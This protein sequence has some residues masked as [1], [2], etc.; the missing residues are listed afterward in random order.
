MDKENRKGSYPFHLIA[1]K[2]YLDAKHQFNELLKTNPNDGDA[3]FALGLI[4]YEQKKYQQAENYLKQSLNSASEKHLSDIT[5]LLGAINQTMHQPQ[6]ALKYY[7]KSIQHATANYFVFNNMAILYKELNQF[8]KAHAHIN[9]ALSLKPNDSDCLNTLSLIYKKENKLSEAINTCQQ[10]LSLD[11]QYSRAWNNLGNLY[12]QQ[13]E[14]N[15]AI[16]CYKKALSIEPKYLDCIN[17]LAETYGNHGHYRKAI[18]YY[19]QALVLNPEDPKQY[20]YLGIYHKKL[21]E[22]DKS[23][24]YYHKALALDP[25]LSSALN[26]LGLVYQHLGDYQQSLSYL[27]KALRLNKDS[28]EYLNNIAI[29]YQFMGEEEKAYEYFNK[30][31]AC[32]NPLHETRFNRSLLLLKKGRLENAWVEFESRVQLPFSK[33]LRE[34]IH[35]LT[36]LSRLT[37]NDSIENN[38][39]LILFEQGLGDFIQYIRFAKN[40]KALGAIVHVEVPLE[41]IS[42]IKTNDY[43]DTVYEYGSSTLEDGYYIPILSLPY[44]LKLDLYSLSTDIPYFSI[45]EK[46]RAAF[47]SL[48]NKSKLNVGLVWGGN[49]K[50][51]ND[52]NRSIP[53]HNF[54]QLITDENINTCCLQVGEYHDQLKESALRQYMTDLSIHLQTFADTAAMISCLDLIISVDTSIVHLAGAL[55]VPCWVLLPTNADWRWFLNSTESIWYSSVRLFRKSLHAS[56]TT[57]IDEV[58]H[59]LKTNHLDCN[60]SLM[61]T[62]KFNDGIS[63]KLVE[64]FFSLIAKGKLSEAKESLSLLHEKNHLIAD[65]TLAHGVIAYYDNDTEQ[66][67]S[68]LH[69]SLDNGLADRKEMCYLILAKIYES[70]AN[71]NEAITYYQRAFDENNLKVQ[72]L[73]KI[74]RIYESM[75]DYEKAYTYYMKVNTVRPNDEVILNNIGRVLKKQFKYKE[76]ISYYELALKQNPNFLEAL[77]NIGT[78]YRYLKDYEKSLYYYNQALKLKSDYEDCLT[79]VAV[80][81]QFTGDEINADK[82]YQKVLS[83]NPHHSGCLNNYA[84]F[85]KERL[86]YKKAIDYFKKALLLKPDNAMYLNNIG[87]CYLSLGDYDKSSE[88][89]QRAIDISPNYYEAIFNRGLMYLINGDYQKGL[90]DYEARLK[91]KE[92]VP[93]HQF[94]STLNGAKPWNGEEDLNNK[95]ILIVK[96]QGYGDYIQ[97]IRFA[98]SLKEKGARVICD[99]HQKLTRLIGHQDYIDEIYQEGMTIDYYVPL[100]S[101]ANLLKKDIHQVGFTQSYITVDENTADFITDNDKL[102]VGFVWAGSVNNANDSIRSM[103]LSTLLPVIQH[104]NIHSYSLQVDD[105]NNDIAISRLHEHVT[106]LGERLSDFYETAKIIKKL[107]L[108]VSVDTAVAH[109]AGALGKP[110]YLMLPFVPDWRWL[111]DR[112]DSPWYESIEIFRQTKLN[113]WDTVIHSIIKRID[114]HGLT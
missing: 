9:K 47:K 32:T 48:V 31:L 15:K 39:V 98:V 45:D 85:H 63:E 51:I 65:I 34:R 21:R 1:E 78:V 73:D 4:A 7:Q 25:E 55:N 22:Y 3:L 10:I 91:N 12:E 30:A 5:M 79:N 99:C 96:E 62:E 64:K 82:Y 59:Q 74:G 83:L 97:F 61:S 105:R 20:N 57:V 84:I 69:E 29:T 44:F 46:K 103:T 40:L 102:N 95:T 114:E 113:E 88:Y 43:V 53:L 87:V 41:L 93:M 56:W 106:D 109:L 38:N 94:I 60:R 90:N 19:E 76:A 86:E 68:L 80:L 101:L 111:R 27:K 16:D 36:K 35:R 100:M 8:D 58:Y 37:Q 11:D 66:A 75:G 50:N 2:Q 33:P 17:N 89:Y 77:N 49:I 110:C 13:N 108:V 107:D 54:Q 72:C 23:I 26:N 18:E 70:K 6:N 67:L 24:H 104:P 28:T 14:L 112:D 52:L 71:F 92:H 81:Y 42:L